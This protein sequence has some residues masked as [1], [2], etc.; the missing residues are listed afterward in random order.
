MKMAD[1]RRK[2]Q[3][4]TNLLQIHEIE[5]SSTTD[6]VGAG[7]S[8]KEIT[9]YFENISKAP[10]D[11][12]SYR[13]LNA[14]TI[15]YIKKSPITSLPRLSFS[16][17]VRKN[18]LIRKCY[19][20]DNLHWVWKDAVLQGRSAFSK[21][22]PIDQSNKGTNVLSNIRDSLRSSFVTCFL[23]LQYIMWIETSVPSKKLFRII[24]Y[25]VG[26]VE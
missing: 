12:S 1:T 26:Y 4:L 14:D 9:D 18:I 5:D 3:R 23:M 21:K 20:K 17:G 24:S 11:K 25:F 7:R 2:L 16:S 15:R 10:S 19:A 13:S 6:F 22:S 8:V